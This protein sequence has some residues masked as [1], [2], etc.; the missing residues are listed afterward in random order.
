MYIP[1]HE[2]TFN[3]LE[4]WD[5]VA[6]LYSRTELS[7]QS[8]A[9]RDAVAARAKE[10]NMQVKKSSIAHQSVDPRYT[11]EGIIAQLP[12]KGLANDRIFT[13][14]YNLRLISRA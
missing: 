2:L 7:F 12:D 11:A 14:L 8:R 4:I 9:N 1:S 10:S 13:N 3:E 5:C 6:Y